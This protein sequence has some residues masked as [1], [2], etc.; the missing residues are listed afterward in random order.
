MRTQRMEVR[1][2]RSVVFGVIACTAAAITGFA[3]APG[4]ASAATFDTYVC[5]GL[6]TCGA[7]TH[8]C[9]DN[10]TSG[11]TTICSVQCPIIICGD[12]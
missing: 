10:G 4:V 11:G 9:C 2:W 7:G 8:E 12:C 1:S 3:V 6:Y 5:T